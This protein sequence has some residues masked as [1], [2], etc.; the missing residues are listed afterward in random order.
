[1]LIVK[2]KTIIALVMTGFLMFALRADEKRVAT[3]LV[4]G[5]PFG[6]WAQGFDN[7]PWPYRA[8]LKEMHDIGVTDIQFSIQEGR[9]AT[10]NYRTEL[11]HSRPQPLMEN[12]DWLD[13][14]LSE[15]EKYGMKVWLIYT[16]PI[17]DKGWHTAPDI[18]SLSDPRL[19]K[20]YCDII[21]EIGAKYGKYKSLAG[22]YHHELDN[23]EANTNYSNR[24]AE[25]SAW[26]QQE[27]GENYSGPMPPATD[28]GNKW[29][30][31]F[32]LYRC[33]IMDDFVQALNRHAAKCGL[34]NV[35][36]YYDIESYKGAS[37]RWG[38]DPV[39]LEKSCDYIWA[40]VRDRSGKIYL[41]LDKGMF[42]FGPSYF[43]NDLTEVF[44][45]AFHGRSILSF[46]EGRASLFVDM[47]RDY[48]RKRKLS[49][50]FYADYMLHTKEMV[51]TF[52]GSKNLTGWLG[53][54]TRW[55]GGETTARIA[56]AG[57]PL[58]FVLKHPEI[59][60][61]AYTRS[62]ELL[63][64]ALDRHFDV[65]GVLLN[66]KFAINPENLKRYDC[67][68]IP[69]DT[70]E[71][72]SAEQ[73][74]SLEK[75]LAGGGKIFVVATPLSSGPRDLTKGT[76][77]TTKLCG[78]QILDSGSP[79]FIQPEISS[80][81]A[82]QLAK[83]QA[84][85]MLSV[86][87]GGAKAAAVDRASG[88]P[89]LYRY[90][91]AWFS[92]VNITEGAEDYLA[93]AISGLVNP[94]LRLSGHDGIYF[95][96]TVKKD[97][98]VCLTLRGNGRT[99]LTID[100]ALADKAD[101]YEL[102]NIITGQTLTS[103]PAARFA[104]PV[105]I[106][107]R[108]KNEPCAL[109][110]G[111]AEKI[112]EF[113][114]IFPPDKSF[115][116]LSQDSLEENPEVVINAPA[117]AGTKIGIYYNGYGSENILAAVSKQPGVNPFILPRLSKDAFALCDLVIIPQVKTPVFFEKIRS[118]LDTW[119]KNGGKLI[120]THAQI[121]ESGK[122]IFSGIA[123]RKQKNTIN[124][125]KDSV[126][127]TIIPNTGFAGSGA[128]KFIPG[129]QFDYFI[130]EPGRDSMVLVRDAKGRPVAVAGKYGKGMVVMFGTLPGQ[131]STATAIAE[132][133]SSEIPEDERLL[134][135]DVINGLTDKSRK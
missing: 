95:A 66:G 90:G 57:N 129:F 11:K 88:T 122:D 8:I 44:M 102:R 94:P 69:E 118:N 119:V 84:G 14:T 43:G 41:S 81:P 23:T 53:L 30:R 93:A 73:A 18:N 49:D 32:A 133:S 36:C 26:C 101:N 115:K 38:Y 37:W 65:D 72:L 127:M 114:G 60:G 87:P 5:G 47:L 27:F 6:V 108:E 62:V 131:F 46:W 55:Q 109:A 20:I 110:F 121:P 68:I 3:W 97:G 126:E 89:I 45:Y 85:R 63:Y 17:V 99:L 33:H 61:A 24:Q 54:M 58:T 19:I 104:Q 134:L 15:A 76:D 91:N 86:K 7:D 9:G 82:A 59:T 51:D 2:A 120:L 125:S 67:I 13:E 103:G 42:D 105:E 64:Q 83:F 92:T 75:Y 80:T 40:P 12:R 70:G 130:L 124:Q 77:L 71:G 106:V 56:V 34:Q 128:R 21:D 123:V 112:A 117:V 132:R 29:W 48:F 22:I 78:L 135:A 31:R 113:K 39:M 79:R 35:F 52:F 16:P 100:P 98:M 1:M 4:P 28:P 116:R 96:E 111:P 74:L 25:F 107:I 50:D 10:F